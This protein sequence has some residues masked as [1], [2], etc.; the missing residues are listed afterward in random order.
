MTG[1]TS[2]SNFSMRRNTTKDLPR[3]GIQGADVF[4]VD[5]SRQS[6]KIN[7]YVTGLFNT[8]RIVLYDTTIKAMTTDQLLFI[9]GHEMG[10]YVLNHSWMLVMLITVLLLLLTWL[11]ARFLPPLIKKF[12]RRLGY[13]LISFTT[14]RLIS[15]LRDNGSLRP[16]THEAG[17]ADP[18]HAGHAVHLAMEPSREAVAAR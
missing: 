12:E 7:A 4:E 16:A 8:K 9:M 3:N 10:H 14:A 2:P 17:V 18:R 15:M 6:N 11:I 5:A 1:T 13:E